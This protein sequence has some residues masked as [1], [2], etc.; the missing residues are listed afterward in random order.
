MPSLS[1]CHLV[2]GARMSEERENWFASNLLH[3]CGVVEHECYEGGRNFN[4]SFLSF[5]SKNH[6]DMDFHNYPKHREDNTNS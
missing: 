2:I 1:V 3:V 6:L 5:A 4:L